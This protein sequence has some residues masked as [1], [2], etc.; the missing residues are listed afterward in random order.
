MS[1]SRGIRGVFSF[2]RGNILVLT[3]TQVL[4]RFFRSMV[5]PYASLYILALGGEPAQIGLINSLR[6]LA[7]LI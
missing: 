5:M 1:G 4:G 2:M 6:P 3:L 7:G